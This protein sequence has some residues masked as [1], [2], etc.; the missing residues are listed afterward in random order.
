M[1]YYLIIFSPGLKAM[2]LGRA[3]P[4]PYSLRSTK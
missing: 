1:D 3:R 4:T 2:G